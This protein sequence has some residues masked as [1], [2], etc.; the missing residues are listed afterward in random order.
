MEYF[1]LKGGFSHLVNILNE[2]LRDYVSLLGQE[3]PSLMTK[4]SI[5]FLLKIIRIFYFSSLN[6]FEVYREINNNDFKSSAK[7]QKEE[8]DLS[9]R[10]SA[11]FEIG[12]LELLFSGK[13]GEE[14][15][16]SLNY[17]YLFSIFVETLLKLINNNDTSSEA[18]NVIETSF[19]FL[20]GI[21]GFAK[22]IEVIE[23][24]LTGEKENDFE[25]I[26]FYGILSEN[27]SI[28]T[29]FSRSMIKLTK[30]CN[31]QRRFTMLSFI[32][33]FIFN[34]I[35]NLNSEQEKYSSEL[36]EFF[37][38]LF[39]IYLSN[40]SDFESRLKANS[41]NPREFFLKLVKTLDDDINLDSST[42]LSN[43]LFIGYMKIITKVCMSVN[44]IK[45]EISSKFNLLEGIMTK[46]LFKQNASNEM[47]EK[48]ARLEFINPDKFD[49]SKT[50]RNSNISIR[51]ECYNFILS[52]LQGSIQNF[53]KFFSVNLLDS[54]KED[55]KKEVTKYSLANSHKCEGYVGI[56]NLQCIC[57]MNSMLQQF[58]MVPSFRYN[59]L[60]VTD[61]I[62]PNMNNY[63]NVDD[64]FLH[65][66]QRMFSFLELSERQDYNPHGFCFSFKDWEGNPTDVKIQQD[67]QE[68][69]NRFFD[70]VDEAIKPT[71]FKYLLSS[72]FGGKT[73]SQIIC[74]NGCGNVKNR[75]EDFYNLSLEVNNM[76]NVND[77]LEKFISPER[78]DDFKCETCNKKVTITKK[79]SLAE[80]PNVLIIHLQ[81]IFFN[82]EIDK[83]EK[84]NSKL[85]FP[86][87]LNLKQYT[88]ED[89]TRRAVAKKNKESTEETNFE[90][91]E[92]DEIYFKH[93]S[94]YEYN[95]VGVVVHLGSADAGHYYSYINTIRN[96]NEME[97]VFNKDDESHMNSW[98]EFNDSRI[99]KFNVSRMDDE[100]FGG[101]DSSESNENSWGMKNEKIKSAY[102]LV[103]ERKIKN[104]LKI[105]I[106]ENEISDKNEVISFKENETFSIKK[107]NDLFRYIDTP[108]FSEVYKK[109][110][111][112]YFYDSAKNEY[113]QYKPYYKTERI[114]PKA[115][116]LEVSD[117]NSLFQKHQNISDEQ[118][119]TFF[120][121]VISVLDDTLS[122]TQNISEETSTKI[123]S[124]F[125]NFIFKILSQKDKNKVNSFNFSFLEQQKRNSF[126]SLIFLLVLL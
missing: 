56:R 84:I 116:Y 51:N 126:I 18:I 104:P 112:S 85:E 5:I 11:S 17:E 23:S 105:K 26:V 29:I 68:F 4:I 53:E 54:S 75:F 106:E 34:F 123:A 47:N 98:L 118:F 99:S 103:Y 64:N 72:I 86:R 1:V 8:I 19:E 37:S 115:Y 44:D 66:V 77:S 58:F 52:L 46:V 117:D 108:E 102:M 92:T 62:E 90:N 96:G 13:I 125:M 122:N 2:R 43:E 32:F 63:H 20:T 50:K 3:E 57:Y 80:L 14:I 124:T 40:T 39:E 69:L 89:M 10:K 78:I 41:Q 35:S 24:K 33:S 93:N 88:I 45:N 49:D 27:I 65:Q 21:L 9:R 121:S 113:F 7:Q 12:E 81:R 70:K 30:I 36:F 42:P 60:Q 95:L 83:N 22:N 6:K 16:N 100:C 87:V 101:S 48:L 79:N 91:F 59:L 73:C 31:L 82:Y 67:S 28:R 97:M 61:E 15:Y 38:F 94:Y 110:T 55:R 111:S 114:I 71:K 107:A 120:D 74:E 109:I 25:K 76:K 119:V